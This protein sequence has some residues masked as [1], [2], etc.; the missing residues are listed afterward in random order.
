MEKAKRQT[1]KGQ[2]ERNARRDPHA[3]FGPLAG[4]G[5]GVNFPV[6]CQWNFARRCL[7][8]FESNEA[9]LVPCSFFLF[10]CDVHLSLFF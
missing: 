9:I 6:C 2:R 8:F 3:E 5:N 7:M 1:D 4:V 10:P